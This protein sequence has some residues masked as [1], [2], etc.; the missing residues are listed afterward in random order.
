MRK[1]SSDMR[2]SDIILD[3]IWLTPTTIQESLFLPND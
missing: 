1:M 2:P 3:Q